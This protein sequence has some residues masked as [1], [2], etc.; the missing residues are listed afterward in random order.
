M[1]TI[2]SWLRNLSVLM[3]AHQ[4][5]D[6]HWRNQVRHR[7]AYDALEERRVLTV[8]L[9]AIAPPNCN[10][11]ADG[12]W[13]G[14]DPTIYANVSSVPAS[15]SFRIEVDQDGDGNADAGWD[16]SGQDTQVQFDPLAINSNLVG[17]FKFLLLASEMD[18]ECST[19]LSTTDCV[20]IR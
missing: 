8:G 17:H 9:D 20:D 16:Q 5:R 14:L 6:G 11:N 3:S 1:R 18:E 2:F 15:A 4:K 10:L 7:Y 19:I 13:E 12:E